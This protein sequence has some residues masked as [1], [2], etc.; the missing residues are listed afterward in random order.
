MTISK[1]RKKPVVIEAIQFTEESKN[2]AFHWISG[3]HHPDWD[4]NGAPTIVIET[5][6]GNLAAPEMVYS[7]RQRLCVVLLEELPDADAG[8]PEWVQKIG[9]IV[10]A[11]E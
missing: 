9:R 10:R 1:F 11:E 4:E 7:L 6:E 5:L 8:S 2:R 3:N